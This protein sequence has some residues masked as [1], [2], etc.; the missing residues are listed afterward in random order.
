MLTLEHEKQQLIEYLRGAAQAQDENRLADIGAEY[1]RFA[2]EASYYDGVAERVETELFESQASNKDQLTFLANELLL[3]WQFWYSW[4]EAAHHDFQIEYMGIE[5][6]D[7]PR[8]ARYIVGKLETGEPIVEPTLLYHFRA[9]RSETFLGKMESGFRCILL[10]IILVL[11]CS[12]V[13]VPKEYTIFG[14]LFIVS[15]VLAWR[16]L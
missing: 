13:W 12:L 10:P 1:E 6:N 15:F 5:K 7:W 3:V 8:F 2:S 4:I 11:S 16:V 9:Q 14:G